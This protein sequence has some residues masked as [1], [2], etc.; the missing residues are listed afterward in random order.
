MAL[1][2]NQRR[3]LAQARHHARLVRDCD[4]ANTERF[5]AK[6]SSEREMSPIE[7]RAWRGQVTGD[8]R[9][10]SHRG[11]VCHNQHMMVMDGC[12]RL[13]KKK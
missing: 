8:L 5:K 10:Y 12:D 9:Q 11:Y 7:R 2:R 6:R 1:T 4:A 13:A 3:K